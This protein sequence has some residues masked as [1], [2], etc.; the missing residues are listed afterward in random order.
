LHDGVVKAR[1]VINSGAAKAKLAELVN[2]SN[3]TLA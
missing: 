2:I 1:E 3:A